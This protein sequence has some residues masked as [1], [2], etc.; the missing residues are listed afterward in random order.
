MGGGAGR[1]FGGGAPSW[2]AVA[3]RRAAGPRGAGGAGAPESR[4]MASRMR[5]PSL[6][7][8]TCRR[9]RASVVGPAPAV[10]QPLLEV[11]LG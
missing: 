3:G 2:P 4:G 6:Q 11:T 10:I 9:D 7:D 1:R 8:I 5:I